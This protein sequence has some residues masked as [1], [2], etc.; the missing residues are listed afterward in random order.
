MTTVPWIERPTIELDARLPF[1]QRFKDVPAEAI[2]AARRLLDDIM[3]QVPPGANLLADAVRVRT[4][5]RF[6]AEAASASQMAGVSWRAIML[7]NLSYD[8]VLAMFGCSTMALATSDGPVLA[9]N[10]DWWPEQLLAQSSYLLRTTKDGQLVF[11]NAGWPG[12][13]G[14][15]TGISGQGFA[16]ALNAVTGPERTERMGYPVLLF[17]RKVIDDARDYHQAMQ[18]LCDQHLVS[19]ALI[20]L[21]GIQNDQRAVIER[22]PRR[23]AVRKPDGDLPLITTNHYQ[24]LFVGGPIGEGQLYQSTCGRLDRLC[25]LLKNRRF[26]SPIDDGFL[27]YLLSDPEVRQTITAQH[28]I[29][30][31]RQQTARLLVPRDLLE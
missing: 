23:F 25:D 18:M 21:V 28:I 13:I 5:N 16:L 4:L 12:A 14:V 19:P 8:L 7:A 27:L 29:L 2:A 9:R 6:N 30:R 24:S 26:D 17:L 22:S 3:R 20:T 15:V 11:A 31:P 10:M 1:E